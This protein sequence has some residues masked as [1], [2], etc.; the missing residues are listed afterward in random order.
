MGFP[1]VK[2]S[3]MSLS[4]E[5]IWLRGFLFE[6]HWG[7]DYI[8]SEFPEI[9]EF[10]SF[11][12]ERERLKFLRKYISDLRVKNGKLFERKKLSFQQEWEKVAV[13]FFSSLSDIMQISWPKNK[14][15]IRAMVAA[16]PICP[17]NLSDWSF[18]IF[19][20]FEKIDA[21]EIIMHEICHFLYF[22]KWHELYPQMNV[23]RFYSPSIEWQ[24][25]EIVAPIILNDERIQKLLKQPAAFYVQHQNL[26]IG[27]KTVQRYFSDL[28]RETCASKNFT[29][30]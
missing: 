27:T 3:I 20:R 1:I 30:F 22:E 24:L 21:L 18:S 11:Q 9:K 19:Y 25:S 23:K 6:D 12:T 7:C 17:K 5:I 16:N 26:K 29:A 2:F 4:K 8:I 28:Y 10:F 14:K 15:V 13:S